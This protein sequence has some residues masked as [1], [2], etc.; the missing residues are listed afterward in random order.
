MGRRLTFP[1]VSPLQP[2]GVLAVAQPVDEGAQ[3]THVLHT[4]GYHHFLLDD[5]SLR[6]IGPLLQGGG[7]WLQNTLA[8]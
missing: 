1:G 5:V 4:S 2:I 6:K 8:L 7:A 3:L